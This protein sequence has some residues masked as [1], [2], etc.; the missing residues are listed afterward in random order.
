MFVR[1]IQH[2]LSRHWAVL[3]ERSSSSRVQHDIERLDCHLVAVH[4]DVGMECE[5][6]NLE[7]GFHSKNACDG[8]V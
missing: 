2:I 7:E 5:G 1:S 4:P 6:H 3:Y 8:N